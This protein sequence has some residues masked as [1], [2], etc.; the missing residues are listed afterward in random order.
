MDDKLKQITKEFKRKQQ[1][2]ILLTCW[3][4]KK[5][6]SGAFRSKPSKGSDKEHNMSLLR[7]L[8]IGD[9]LL[10]NGT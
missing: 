8:C 7:V 5:H 6:K 10:T 4:F 2:Q 1:G 3:L 9:K